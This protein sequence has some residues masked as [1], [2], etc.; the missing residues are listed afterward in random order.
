MRAVESDYR[1][2]QLGSGRLSLP[3]CRHTLLA[4][5][6]HYPQSSGAGR[7]AHPALRA[8]GARPSQGRVLAAGSRQ[9]AGDERT[10]IATPVPGGARQIAACLLSGPACRACAVSPP[11]QRPWPRRH[12]SRGRVRRRSNVADPPA[13]TTWKR[14]ARSSCRSALIV[15][16]HAQRTCISSSVNSSSQGS[17]LMS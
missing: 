11:W 8:V 3:A 15:E 6:V 13:P 17:S 9:R 10:V 5:A 14:S 1:D 4:G 2:L 7:S 16:Q 12:R